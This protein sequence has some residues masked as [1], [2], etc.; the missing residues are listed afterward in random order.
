VTRVTV[1][2]SGG[3]AIA[4]FTGYSRALGGPVVEI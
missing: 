1:R 2:T 4:E 3:Q